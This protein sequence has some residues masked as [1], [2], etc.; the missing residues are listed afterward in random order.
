M[1]IFCVLTASAYAS[2]MSPVS[3]LKLQL[4]QLKFSA[5]IVMPFQNITVKYPAT[6]TNNSK[7]RHEVLVRVSGVKMLPLYPVDT[8]RKWIFLDQRYM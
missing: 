4:A 6:M 8:H 1:L 2:W 5:F 3:G 7:G